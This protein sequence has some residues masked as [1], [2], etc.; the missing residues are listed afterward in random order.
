M[1]G[2]TLSSL[3]SSKTGFKFSVINSGFNFFYFGRT[4]ASINC[5]SK[6]S[7]ENEYNCYSI[8]GMFD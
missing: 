2:E 6:F 4:G 8:L 1:F 3:S 7:S 5:L